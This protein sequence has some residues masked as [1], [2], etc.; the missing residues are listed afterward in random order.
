MAVWFPHGATPEEKEEELEEL[1]DELQ[2][3]QELAEKAMALRHVAIPQMTLGS[4][5][6]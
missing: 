6:I 2:A 5:L 3:K 4:I 1:H